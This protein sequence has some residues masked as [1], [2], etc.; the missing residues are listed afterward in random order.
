LTVIFTRQTRQ[1]RVLLDSE[2]RPASMPVSRAK[3]SARD[4]TNL[5]GDLVLSG[6]IDTFSE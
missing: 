1:E 5:L 6:W 3:I 4:M 2:R